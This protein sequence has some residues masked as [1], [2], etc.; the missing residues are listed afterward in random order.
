M[1]LLVFYNPVYSAYCLLRANLQHLKI[2]ILQTIFIG[3]KKSS[4]ESKKRHLKDAII[5]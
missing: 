5:P 2:M 1:Y 4:Y 3:L